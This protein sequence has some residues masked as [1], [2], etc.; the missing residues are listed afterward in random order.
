MKNVTLSQISIP[1]NS[2]GHRG[3]EDQFR[4]QTS[5]VFR[6]HCLKNIFSVINNFR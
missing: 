4:S 2:L 3:H 6:F 1:F 5:I